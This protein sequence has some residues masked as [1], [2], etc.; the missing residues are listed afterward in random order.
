MRMRVWTL[1]HFELLSLQAYFFEDNDSDDQSASDLSPLIR[2]PSAQATPT[3]YT[4]IITGYLS[5]VELIVLVSTKLKTSL[6]LLL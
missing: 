4:H 6:T 1:Q 3:P 5:I 2:R